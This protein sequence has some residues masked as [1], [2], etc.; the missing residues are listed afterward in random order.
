MGRVDGKHPHNCMCFMGQIV[1][2]IT[3]IFCP[4]LLIRFLDNYSRAR[5][6]AKQSLVGGSYLLWTQ[7]RVFSGTPCMY[8]VL[9][10]AHIYL[11]IQFF[12]MRIPG[13]WDHHVWRACTTTWWGLP[14]PSRW[15]SPI[16]PGPW[17]RQIS[18]D[19]NFEHYI[20]GLIY[21]RWKQ[22]SH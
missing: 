16:R 1:T 5:D 14:T 4:W 3:S 2:S 13:H 22:I 7:K 19:R 9:S 8:V 18:S 10:T 6:A 17:C 20:Y 21:K 12:M 11:A 15:C